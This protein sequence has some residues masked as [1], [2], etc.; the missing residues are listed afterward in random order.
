M[1]GNGTSWSGRVGQEVRLEC[2]ARA[3]PEE[4]RQGLVF[5]LQRWWWR[6]GRVFWVFDVDSGEWRRV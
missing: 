3:A 1:R 5:W 2:E 6:P 4:A